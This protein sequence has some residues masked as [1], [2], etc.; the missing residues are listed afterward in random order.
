MRGAALQAFRG[1]NDSG[2]TLAGPVGLGITGKEG[3]PRAV[4]EVLSQGGQRRMGAEG[5]EDTWQ[6]LPG[7]PSPWLA[8]CQTP[9]EGGSSRTLWHWVVMSS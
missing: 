2:K 1:W 8:C 3:G 5:T 9:P 4:L 7:E 6:T